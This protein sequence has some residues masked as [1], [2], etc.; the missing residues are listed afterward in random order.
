MRHSYGSAL[1]MQGVPM[2]VIAAVLGHAD[3]RMT[4]KHYAALAPSYVAETIR[5]NLPKLGIVEAGNVTAF[6]ARPQNR[7]DPRT[8]RA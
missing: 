3:T 8:I 4:E 5:A 2:G 6:R 7:H 1:A